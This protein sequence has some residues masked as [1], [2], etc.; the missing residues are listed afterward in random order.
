MCLRQFI[1]SVVS[2]D[3]PMKLHFTVSVLAF[4][5]LVLASCAN[6][7]ASPR[8]DT[9]AE[10]KAEAEATAEITGNDIKSDKASALIESLKAGEPLATNAPIYASLYP[11]ATLS[12]PAVYAAH[13]GHKGGMAEFTTQASPEDIM[14]H[15]RELAEA[16]GL[17]PVMEMNQG[18][19]RAFAAKDTNGAELQVVAAP[20]AEEELTSVQLTWQASR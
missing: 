12:A 8:T 19:A 9:E 1:S 11:E 7:A 5:S 6:D 13:D 2:Y 14:A 16:S 17:S 18:T 15:Y 3:G 10:A 20:V 4:S